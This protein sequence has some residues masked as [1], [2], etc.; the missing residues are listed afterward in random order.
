MENLIQMLAA[1]HPSTDVLVGV[2]LTAL[3]V[4]AARIL[5]AVT[6]AQQKL[7]VQLFGDTQLP[8]VIPT[9]RKDQED[10]DRRLHRVRNDMQ[11]IASETGVTLPQR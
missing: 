8:G 3:M 5:W 7:Q 6:Q 11:H 4:W 9:I 2:P 10:F 1:G